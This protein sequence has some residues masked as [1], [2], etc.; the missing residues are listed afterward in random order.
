M[1]DSFYRDIAETSVDGLWVIGLDGSTRYANPALAAMF[2]ASVEEFCRL[3]VFDTLDEQGCEQFRA[4]LVDLREGRV[5]P[6][7]VEVLFCRRD[8]SALWTLVSEKVLR[9]ADGGVLGVLQ[10]VSNNDGRRRRMDELDESRRQLAEAH[11]I[12]RLGSWSLDAASGRIKVSEHLVEVYGLDRDDLTL[13]LWLESVHDEDR[14]EVR[15]QLEAALHAGTDFDFLARVRGRDSWIWTRGRGVAHHD[16]DGAIVELAGTHQDVTSHKETEQALEHQLARNALLQAIATAANEA[17]TLADAFTDLRAT[18]RTHRNWRDVSLYLPTADGADVATLSAEDDPDGVGRDVALE[19]LEGGCPTWDAS[20]TVLGFPLSFKG[21][22]QAV[23][24]LVATSAPLDR[25]ATTTAVGQAATQLVRVIE[26]EHAERQLAA[27]RD[28]ALRASQAKSE[29]LAVMSHEIRTP[30]NGVLGLDELLLRTPLA[31]R[32]RQLATGVRDAGRSL[33]R[34]INDVLD[35]SKIEAG[36]L[37]LE[38][39]DFDVRDVCDQAVGLMSDAARRKRL[40]LA[41]ACHPDVPEILAGDPTRLGQVIAN[42]V[43]NAVKFTEAG[44]VL[45]DVTCRRA[46]RRVELRV[47]VTDSGIGVS[48]EAQ[49]RIFDDFAQADVSTT[50][51][52]GGTGL[53][54]SISRRIV[55]ALEGVLTVSSEPGEGSTFSFTAVL[56]APLGSRTSPDDDLARSRLSGGRMLGAQRRR[57]TRRAPAAPARAVAGAHRPGPR[58]RP[59]GDRHR[60]RPRGGG[61]LRG[62]DRRRPGRPPARGARGRATDP[63]GRR[64]A[65][66]P[67]AH[68]APRRLR[69]RRAAGARPGARQAGLQRHAARRPRRSRRARATGQRDHG[70]ARTP[71]PATDP[72]GRGQ[73][74][75]PDGRHRHAGVAR[76]RRGARRGRPG[77]RRGLR[78]GAPR[79]RADGPP[80]AAHGRVRRDPD[81][82][83]ASPGRPAY[84]DPGDDRDHGR[85]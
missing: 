28:A 65:G 54:L 67:G 39:V 58:R 44:H 34:L 52:H 5:D 12:A 78:P 63:A 35:L 42:L 32:Q 56:D 71:G 25:S 21:H 15:R 73:P 19:T 79:R 24:I 30:L 75:Q 48:R 69:A 1:D 18:L 76:L 17:R 49:E 60:G 50:R 10:R 37:E 36:H 82:A 68:P 23:A 70:L 83:V 77:V 7:P 33:L 59:G 13:A 38:R 22:V 51:I 72:G 45:V 74:G 16:A 84:A 46:G 31:P 55:E 85:R 14:E 41:V 81:A 61:P 6:E 20:G 11:S 80:D 47:E 57:A 66:L 4:H 9:D 8:G 3:T 2:G 40:E 62:R 27:A 64:A 53:G 26:R 29:F 43:S